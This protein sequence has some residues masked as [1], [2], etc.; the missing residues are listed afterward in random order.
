MSLRMVAGET[1]G[2]AAR[3]GPSTRPA[4]GSGRSPRTMARRTASLRSSLT[5]LTSTVALARLALALRRRECQLRTLALRQLASRRVHVRPPAA[6][7]ACAAGVHGSALPWIRAPAGHACRGSAALRV[8]AA[9]SGWS[10]RTSRPAGAAP[11]CAPRRAAGST[12]SCWRTGAAAPGRSRSGPG[13]GST[14]RRC[15]SSPPRTGRPRRGAARTRQRLGRRRRAAGADRPRVPDPGRGHATTPS[16]WRRSGAHDLRVEGVVVEMLRRRRRP[17]RRR[18][19]L[20]ARAGP[21]ARGPRRPPGG[22]H[23]GVAGGGRRDPGRRGCRRTCWWSVTRTS[24]SGRR[25]GRSGSGLRGLAARSRAGGRGRTACWPRSAGRTPRRPTSPRGW[26][27][28]L[29]ARRLVRRPRAGP[30]RP[31]RAADRL[32]HRG[33]RRT[34]EAAAGGNPRP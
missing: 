1:P 15:G 3:P 8:A 31:G 34:A 25:C 16:W 27:R 32:R 33:R 22:R 17:R 18:R 24:T 2:S 12:W 11:S 28:I 21:P 13:S 6:C 30:A 19:R 7:H 4:P 26:Q 5:G 14:A 29:A 10:W 9:E 23:Q 20:R